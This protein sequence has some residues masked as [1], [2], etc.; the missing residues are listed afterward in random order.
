MGRRNAALQLPLWASGNCRLPPLVKIPVG[1]EARIQS[2]LQVV[3]FDRE[4]HRGM[5]HRIEYWAPRH[6][7]APC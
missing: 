3:R 7:R 2:G 4:R 6:P 5:G 1:G